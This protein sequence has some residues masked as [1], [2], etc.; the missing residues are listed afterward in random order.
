MGE[1]KQN[2]GFPFVGEEPFHIRRIWNIE[3]EEWFY[4]ITDVVGVLIPDSPDP[5]GYW[6][7]LK[8]RL[9]EEEGF[10][11]TT[12]QIIQYRLKSRDGKFRLTDA[13]NRQTLLRLIQSIPSPQAEPMRLWLAQVGEERFEEIEH[14]EAALERIRETYRAKG[15]DNDWIDARIR[16]DL[17]RNELTD[18]WRNRG[19][20]EEIGHFAILTNVLTEGTFGLTVVAYKNYKLLPVRANLRDHMTPLELAL[21]SLSEATAITLHRNRDS[22]GFPALKRDATD[23]GT[24]AGK[25]R[26]VIEADVGQPVVSTENYLHLKQVRGQAK[27]SGEVTLS[28]KRIRRSQKKTLRQQQHQSS[29]FDDPNRE[30][31]E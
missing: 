20:K 30:Y 14:P 5:N 31:K 15:Y 9:K 18:E 27:K 28:E 3:R 26:E 6:R 11:E 10:D 22:Q 25:A 19:A 16:G 8:R 13:A 24:T 2:L 29:L 17:I 7:T 4:S 12:A 1:E 23:A 21:T